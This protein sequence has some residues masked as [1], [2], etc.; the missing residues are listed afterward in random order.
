MVKN[1]ANNKEFQT[2]LDGRKITY[3]I[4]ISNKAKNARLEI[5]PGTG[6]LVILP[7]YYGIPG[8]PELLAA[9]KRWLLQK[10]P[11]IKVMRLAN[12][13]PEIKI[14]DKIMF[15]GRDFTLV[16]HDGCKSDTET[17]MDNENLLINLPFNISDNPEDML[18]Q[19]YKKQAISVID[20]RVKELSVKTGVDYNKVTVRSQ[21]T[22]WGSCSQKRNL[23]FNWKLV[24]LPR[25]VLDYVV[26]H[27][28]LHIREMNHSRKFW[29]LVYQYCPD[30]KKHRKWLRSYNTLLRINTFNWKYLNTIDNQ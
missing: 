13:S 27:E 25:L 18:T 19:W 4:K 29:E 11:V 7:K 14:G 5:R 9:N 3:S 15:L 20:R 10:L 17:S 30:Y 28:L 8:V 16:N 6:L 21:R 12:S 22:R 24:M 1:K 2:V 26:I 23:S